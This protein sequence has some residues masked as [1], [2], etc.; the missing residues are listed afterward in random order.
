MDDNELSGLDAARLREKYVE[1]VLLEEKTGHIGRKNRISGWKRLI[2]DRLIAAGSDSERE[3]MPLLGHRS[4]AVRFSAA[5]LV[6]PFNRESYADILKGLA[7][8][9]GEIGREARFALRS[10][11]RE[12]QQGAATPA[13]VRQPDPDWL[14]IRHWQKDNLPPAAMARADFENRVLAEFSPARAPQI[15]GLVRVAIGLWPQQ[16]APADSPLVSRHGGPL[17]AP[18]GWQWPIWE[19]EPLFFLGQIHCPD[20]TGLPGAECLPEDGLLTFFGDHDVITGCMPGG[21]SEEG[22]VGDWPVE[23]LVAASPPLPPPSEYLREYGDPTHLLFR[24]FL[25]LPD[26]FSRIVEALG[27]SSEELDAYFAL[28]DAARHHGIPEDVAEHCQYDKLLG[29]PDLVQNDFDLEQDGDDAYRLL[30]QLPGRMGPGGSL[31]FFIRDE[32]LAAR[33]FDRCIFEAQNT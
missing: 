11:E 21:G 26:P 3:V 9:T 25:D 1:M 18:P 17:L 28:G 10:L 5:D 33:R 4:A 24:P 30:A 29:W 27:L 15:L 2:G 12:E 19:E 8:D 20:L 14:R 7:S 31:Y 16:Q 13:P 23:G 32:D 22:M 6:K